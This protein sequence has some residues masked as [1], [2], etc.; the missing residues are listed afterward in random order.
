MKV[1]FLYNFYGLIFVASKLMNFLM[2]WVILVQVS[3]LTTTSLLLHSQSNVNA[4][5]TIVID[6]GHGGK[7]PGAVAFGIKEKEITLSV[8]LKLGKLIKENY[9]DVKVVYTRTNDE[10]IELYRRAKIANN[11]KADLFISIHV[12]SSK[13]PDPYGAET[14]VMGLSKSDANLDVAMTENAVILK[15]DDYKS[16]Y[17]GFDPHSPEAYIIFSLY[18]NAFLDLS[19]TFSSFIQQEYL[20][21]NRENRGVKQA[22]FLVLWKTAMPSVLTEI[23]FISNAEEAAYLSDER[24][25]WLIAKSIFNAF[26]KY[27]AQLENAKPIEL[28]YKDIKPYIA[29]TKQ[30]TD[31]IKK[32]KLPKDTLY[33]ATIST[34]SVQKNDFQKVAEQFIQTKSNDS[35]YFYVQIASS[36]KPIKHFKVS[37]VEE[38]KVENS[39]KYICA[40]SLTYAEVLEKQK[41]I[42]KMYPDAFIIA[43]KNGKKIPI[44]EALKKTK[45]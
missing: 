44:N 3:F 16:Q 5:S 43:I 8:A 2:K 30:A 17:E 34:D 35:V 32:N 18:Q 37:S 6:A 10:F 7:D 36:D 26:S 14:Y 15:E 31:T 28:E 1:L 25:H 21:I 11:A 9:R 29:D 20:K 27:K 12:N 39:F 13:K 38:I 33:K 4:V 19:L 23:G 42:K 40:K 24:N 22:G 41:E 45:N